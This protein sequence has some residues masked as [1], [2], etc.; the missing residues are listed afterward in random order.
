M[1]RYD[2]RNFKNY[3]NF[4][5]FISIFFIN[6]SEFLKNFLKNFKSFS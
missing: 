4:P 6:F 2:Y 5:K 3:L 1:K